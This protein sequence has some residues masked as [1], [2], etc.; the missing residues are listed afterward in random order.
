MSNSFNV[1]ALLHVAYTEMSKT[2]SP[3]LN[4]IGNHGGPKATAR[5]QNDARLG[6]R[7]SH[8][9]LQRC[10]KACNP[11]DTSDLQLLKSQGS[12]KHRTMSRPVGLRDLTVKQVE[13]CKAFDF[14]SNF[15]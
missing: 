13:N 14:R 12:T 4:A 9:P 10:T 1:N 15:T 6:R 7:D 8:L 3:R 2:T 5:M 11:D